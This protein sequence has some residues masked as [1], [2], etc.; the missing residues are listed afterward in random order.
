MAVSNLPRGRNIKDDKEF[1]KKYFNKNVEKV[2]HLYLPRDVGYLDT[3]K[4]WAIITL[5]DTKTYTKWVSKI[6]ATEGTKTSKLYKTQQL[7]D[8]ALSQQEFDKLKRE[9]AEIAAYFKQTA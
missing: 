1:I 4:G 8:W 5:K 7:V 3:L 9:E 2:E 6:I